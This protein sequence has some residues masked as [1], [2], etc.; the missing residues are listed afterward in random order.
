MQFNYLFNFLDRFAVLFEL[1][2]WTKN[3]KG[4]SL[5]MILHMLGYYDCKEISKGA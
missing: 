1:I 4:K 3:S 2:G 5:G